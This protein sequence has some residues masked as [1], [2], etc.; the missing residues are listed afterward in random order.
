M[1]KCVA[2]TFDDGPGEYTGRLLDELQEAGTPATFFLVGQNIAKYPKVVKRMAEAGH[3]LG[4]HTWDH[5]DITTLTREKIEHELNWTSAA[6][7][8]AAGSK[9]SV[10]RPPYGAHGAVYDRL[11]PYPLV[12]W[13]VDTLDWKH[14]DPK[15][16]VSTAM[17]E[18][19]PGSIILMHDIHE[20]SIKA[21]PELVSKL[22]AEG[23][24][25]VTVDQLFD[26]DLENSVAYSAAPRPAAAK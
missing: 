24:T 6:I 7:E 3:Q 26:G 22:K 10:F 15:K 14:H 20:S 17:E 1:D 21:V 13:D 25:P 23:Y 18:V 9:P 2:L 12:L 4:S 16:T 8:K 19:R 5:A 11:V